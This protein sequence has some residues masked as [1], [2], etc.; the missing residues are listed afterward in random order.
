MHSRNVPFPDTGSETV[1]QDVT[2]AVWG[3]RRR[4]QDS[5]TV[6]FWGS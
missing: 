6:T 4:K 3:L 1:A 2:I 5:V